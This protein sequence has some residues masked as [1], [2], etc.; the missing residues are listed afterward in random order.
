MVGIS[1]VLITESWNP[2]MEW[3]KRVQTLRELVQ[4]APMKFVSAVGP[5]PGIKTMTLRCLTTK[6]ERLGE[7]TLAAD[8]DRFP[9]I[10]RHRTVALQFPKSPCFVQKPIAK[11]HTILK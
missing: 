10:C 9:T 1:G 11:S 3:L 5:N 4:G 8:P 2:L 6:Q 7:R